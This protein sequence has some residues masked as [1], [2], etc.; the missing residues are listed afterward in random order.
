MEQELQKLNVG[1]IKEA[2]KFSHFARGNRQQAFMQGFRFARNNLQ[3]QKGKLFY[4]RVAKLI[5]L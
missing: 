1:K 5:E 2:E 4:K 3:K